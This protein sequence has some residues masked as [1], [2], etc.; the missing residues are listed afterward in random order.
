MN[1][2]AGSPFRVVKNTFNERIEDKLKPVKD[3]LNILRRI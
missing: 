1:L 3:F 2:E